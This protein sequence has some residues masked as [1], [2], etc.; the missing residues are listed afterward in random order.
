MTAKSPNNT[1]LGATLDNIDISESRDKEVKKSC[2]D[3]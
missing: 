3:A 1:S 2:A